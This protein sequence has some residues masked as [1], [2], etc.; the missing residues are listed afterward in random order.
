ANIQ[1]IPI[2]L[3]YI[4]MSMVVIVLGSFGIAGIPGTATIAASVSLSGMGLQAAF[5]AISPILAVDPIIDMGR[6]C[7]NVSGSMVN[8]LIV[9]KTLGTLDM[10]LY[11]NSDP[12]V[13]ISDEKEIE[14]L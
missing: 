4:V 3:T 12:D 2:D 6:T 11:K 10:D 14:K 7:L 13:L 9:D 5:P 8:A 1:G